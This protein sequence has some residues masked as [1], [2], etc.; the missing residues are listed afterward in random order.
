MQTA[1]PFELPADGSMTREQEAQLTEDQRWALKTEFVPGMPTDWSSVPQLRYQVLQGQVYT[2][3][4]RRD[5]QTTRGQVNLAALEA[6]RGEPVTD[7]GW[8]DP[9][10]QFLGD[11][12]GFEQDTEEPSVMQG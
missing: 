2:L 12:P 8:Y 5:G 9:M 10:G 3:E 6:L 11:D 1:L 7:E 4:R